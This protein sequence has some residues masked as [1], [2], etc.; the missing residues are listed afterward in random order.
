MY[1]QA[2]TSSLRAIIYFD[3]IHGYLPPVAAPPSKAPMLRMLKQARAFGVGQLLATQNPV[4]VDYKALSNAGTWFIGKLQ[5]E[6]DKQRLLDGLEGAAQGGFKRSDYDKIISGLD[7]RI[8]LMH[9]VH[10]KAASIFETRWA[11]NYLAGPLT[12]QQIPRVNS[13]AGDLAKQKLSKAEKENAIVE[14]ALSSKP[15]VPSGVQEV[16]MPATLSLEASAEAYKRD[17][18]G[19]STRLDR[20]GTAALQRAQVQHRR[21]DQEDRADRGRACECQPPLG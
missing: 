10:E 13:L 17:V 1:A 15:T 19:L 14:D 5:A 21:R 9:N 16:F 20:A 4:D 8:F 11:M 7:K 6:R 12:R 2:G 3:E 18:P